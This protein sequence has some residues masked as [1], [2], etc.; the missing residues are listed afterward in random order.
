MN[1][2]QPEADTEY[3]TPVGG[4]SPSDDPSTATRRLGLGLGLAGAG[5]LLAAEFTPL[6]RVE[7][8]ARHPELIRTVPTGPHHGWAL[9]PIA[10]L[11]VLITLAA[12]R[13]GGDR[14]LPHTLLG[15]LGLVA[16]GIALLADLPDIHATGL[17]GAPATGLHNAAARP[18]IGLYLETLGAVVLM[19]AGAAGRLLAPRRT[20]A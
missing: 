7:T 4:K 19:L 1:T 10:A 14:R 9:V 20:S 11:A 8:V 6:L 3:S 2:T 15:L 12:A 17:V 16:L 18:A 13:A 5:L